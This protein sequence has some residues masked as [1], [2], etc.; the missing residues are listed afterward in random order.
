MKKIFIL[1]IVLFSS[2][3]LAQ[4]YWLPLRINISIPAIF[5][6]DSLFGFSGSIDQLDTSSIEIQDGY[7]SLNPKWD[8]AYQHRDTNFWTSSGVVTINFIIDSFQKKLVDFSFEAFWNHSTENQ[9]QYISHQYLSSLG[10]H[11]SQLS[12]GRTGDTLLISDSGELCKTELDTAWSFYKDAYFYTPPR[13]QHTQNG[14]EYFSKILD[15]PLLFKCNMTFVLIKPVNYVSF[16]G[17]SQILSIINH[18]VSFPT[19]EFPKP[20]LIYDILGREIARHEIPAGAS[21]YQIPSSQFPNGHYFA[22]LGNMTAHFIV[23]N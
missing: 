7:T 12:F 9:Y 19:T 14:N 23:E 5:T 2:D 22:R 18:K 20:I 4:E 11:F 3:I 13:A 6:H 10:I 8:S 1:F 15:E 16:I 21:E 17:N